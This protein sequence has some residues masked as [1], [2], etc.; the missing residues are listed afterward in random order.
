[1]NYDLCI[2]CVNLLS[3]FFLCL[4]RLVLILIKY[5]DLF[6]SL[7]VG[8]KCHASTDLK[9]GNHIHEIHDTCSVFV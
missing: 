3:H 7:R 6:I 2:T 8:N 1:M 5:K 4:S 9:D